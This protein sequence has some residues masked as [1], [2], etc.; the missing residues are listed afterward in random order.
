MKMVRLFIA[1]MMLCV[2]TSAQAQLTK[3]QLKQ[4]KELKSQ[5]KDELN[6][7]ASKYARQE[8]KTFKK[9]GWLVAPGALPLEKQL[10]RSYQMQNEFDEELFPM[11]LMGE[12][13]STAQSYDAAKMQA[14]EMARQQLAAQLQTEVTALIESN[15]S[16]NQLGA[17]EAATVSKTIMSAKSL[18]S[19][20]LGR[21]IPVV[22]VYRD[23][24]NGNK[25]VSVRV[26][27]SSKTAKAVV[28]KAIQD[29]LEKEGKSLQN[30]LDELLGW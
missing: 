25:E 13:V 15:V 29:D 1:A 16:N 22:E 11:Y 18:I 20:S 21:T 24:K 28:K 30:K 6:E 14:M 8:A 26:A 5:T 23:K 4:R 7:K 17:E 2:V 3:E 9:Q 12:G 19:K 27:Y 10:D